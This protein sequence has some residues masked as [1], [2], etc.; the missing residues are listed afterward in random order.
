MTHSEVALSESNIVFDIDS[1]DECSSQD[2]FS[3]WH[4][5]DYEYIPDIDDLWEK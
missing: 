5:P 2:L 3:A 1:Y 4:N